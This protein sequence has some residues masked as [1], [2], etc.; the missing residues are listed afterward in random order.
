MAFEHRAR[1]SGDDR[2]YTLWTC[3]WWAERV[4]SAYAK[5]RCAECS[6]GTS[7]ARRPAITHV[8]GSGGPHNMSRITSLLASVALFCL[9]ISVPGASANPIAVSGGTIWATGLAE[10]GPAA[11][12][13][14]P[15]FS[16]VGGMTRVTVRA[17]TGNTF[18]AKG[19]SERAALRCTRSA[20]SCL[21]AS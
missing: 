10:T 15:G 11:F 21:G 8:N 4:Q 12:T 13:G 2:F 17:S 6:A 14:F 19:I 20:R 3:K 7:L 5:L 18:L 9:G 16:F 1:V